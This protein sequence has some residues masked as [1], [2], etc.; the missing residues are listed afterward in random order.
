MLAFAGCAGEPSTPIR[1]DGDASVS[2][3][4]PSGGA[5]CA[6][7]V[8]AHMAAENFRLGESGT[9]NDN[10]GHFHVMVD[11]DS[12]AVGETIPSDEQHL[13]FGDGSGQTVLDLA[14]GEHS[15][16]LQAADGQH[17]A[18]PLTDEVS[19]T[20][21][22]ASVSF[23]APEDGA[24]ITSPVGVGFETSENLSVEPA[25]EFGQRSGHFHVLVDTEPVTV[26][27]PIPSSEHHKHFGD[28]SE[29]AELDI[30]QGTHTLTLQM[31]DGAHLALPEPDS[32]EVAVGG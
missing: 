2:F 22:E 5:T 25:G 23:A 1:I 24:S 14:T 16:V 26:G 19:V 20:V 21:E 28:G 17:R 11:T 27:D 7:G 8:L 10:A 6:N 31:G 13:H 15:P 3:E 9:V 12:V 30:S 18:L 4:M 29:S 32:I